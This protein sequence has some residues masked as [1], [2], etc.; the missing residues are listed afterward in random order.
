MLEPV[1]HIP[2]LC[3]CLVVL[4]PACWTGAYFAFAKDLFCLSAG[5]DLF[6]ATILD[7]F[8]CVCVCGCLVYEYTVSFP[9]GCV[10]A[11]LVLLGTH[12][13]HVALGALGL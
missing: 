1:R 4:A 12:G 11:V 9:P 8:A 6:C 2:E 5:M 13:V 7:A 3:G 10:S